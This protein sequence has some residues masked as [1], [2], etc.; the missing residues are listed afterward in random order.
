MDAATSTL[1]TVHVKRCM[2]VSHVHTACC[3][4]VHTVM[5]SLRRPA[6]NWLNHPCIAPSRPCVLQVI[7]ALHHNVCNTDHRHRHGFYCPHFC[8]KSI[9]RCIDVPSAVSSAH[10]LYSSSV[11]VKSVWEYSHRDGRNVLCQFE[12]DSSMCT[13]MVSIFVPQSWT[14]KS[15]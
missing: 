8:T 15:K 4:P 14:G 1:H 6:S 2:H 13:C 10:R 9:L 3:R 5:N 11:I 12:R 7:G